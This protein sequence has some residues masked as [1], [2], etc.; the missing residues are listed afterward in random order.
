M[1]DD[2]KARLLRILTTSYHTQNPSLRLMPPGVKYFEPGFIPDSLTYIYRIQMTD[3]LWIYGYSD[4]LG[5][6][7]LLDPFEWLSMGGIQ[8]LAIQRDMESVTVDE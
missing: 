4:L 6:L 8:I 5:N 7:Y 3:G 2:R 1:N